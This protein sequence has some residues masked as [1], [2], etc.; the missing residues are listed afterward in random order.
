MYIHIFVLHVHVCGCVYI[1]FSVY[2]H[3]C[4][5]LPNGGYKSK[6]VLSVI[7]QVQ[8]NT[9]TVLAISSANS[10]FPVTCLQLTRCDVTVCTYKVVFI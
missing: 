4:K 3:V 8:N 5:C 7:T 9:H 6:S 2:I 1:F 10:F